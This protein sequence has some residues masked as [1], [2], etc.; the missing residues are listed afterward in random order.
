MFLIFLLIS[1]SLSFVLNSSQQTCTDALFTDQD[2]D[3]LQKI[4]CMGKAKDPNKTGKFG[5]GFNSVYHITEVPSFCSGK[6][7]TFSDP[8]CLYVLPGKPGMRIHLSECRKYWKTFRGFECFGPCVS[9]EDDFYNG[10]LFRFPLRTPASAEMSEIKNEAV[11]RKQIFQ[12]FQDFAETG[13]NALLFLKNLTWIELYIDSDD[14]I[15]IP[16]LYYQVKCSTQTLADLAATRLQI[17][18]LLRS[19]EDH[20]RRAITLNNYLAIEEDWAAPTKSS[21]SEWIV[22]QVVGGGKAGNFARKSNHVEKNLKPIGGVAVQLSRK[23]KTADEWQSTN[24]EVV[25]RAHCSLPLPLLTGL[26]FHIN[27]FFEL[28]SSRR[29]ITYETHTGRKD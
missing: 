19:P 20:P 22:V 12:L 8:Q 24:E 13:P 4:G 25:G 21:I 15:G 2:Y 17:N 3:N 7:V 11:S 23:E 27:G 16:T 29:N 10:T 6:S 5:I 26:P 1:F 14:A 18:Q 9:S 28:S